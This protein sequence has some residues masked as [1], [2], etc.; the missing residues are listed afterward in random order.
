MEGLDS[1]SATL[2]QFFD[3]CMHLE[4]VE[5]H[6]PLAKKIVHAK[7]EHKGNGKEKDHGKLESHH[8]R[9]HSSGKHHDGK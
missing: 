4:K 3:T 2:K 9:H 1:S 5:M 8:K 7:K 6:K